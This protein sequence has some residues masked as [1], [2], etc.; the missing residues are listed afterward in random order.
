MVGWTDLNA[1]L[2]DHAALAR[3]RD[4]L[5]DAPVVS[6]DL[7]RAIQTADALSRSKRLAH[8]PA[9]REIHFGAWEIK[10]FAEA[11][12]SDPDRIRAFWDQPGDVSAPDGESWNQLFDR[13]TQAI[14]HYTE[15]GDEN[16]IVVAHFGAILT[17]VQQA[18]GCDA[19]TVFGHKIDNLSVTDMELN[20][21]TWTVGKINHCP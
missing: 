20:D 7:Q 18:L 1:D 2:T 19:R 17:L 14:Q 12:A 4:Y 13:V 8:N 5:P 16:L 10:T 21:G 6:S 15:Q 9:L 3:L 11:E